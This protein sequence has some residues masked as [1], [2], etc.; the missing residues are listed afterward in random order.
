MRQNNEQVCQF[1]NEQ[2]KNIFY[3]YLTSMFSITNNDNDQ[4]Y[5]T[6]RHKRF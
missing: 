1:A 5:I 4:T 6:A 2:M 3:Y